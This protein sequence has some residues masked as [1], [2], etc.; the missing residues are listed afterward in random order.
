ML[1]HLPIPK[2]VY[3]SRSGFPVMFHGMAKQADDCTQSKVIYSLLSESFDSLRGDMFYGEL[4]QFQ[5]RFTPISQLVNDDKQFKRRVML[6]TLGS[7]FNTFGMLSAC[8]ANLDLLL[9][10]RERVRPGVRIT[11]MVR[12]EG[13]PRYYEDADCTEAWLE[14]LQVTSYNDGQYYVLSA[15]LVT[16][17]LDDPYVQQFFPLDEEGRFTIPNRY[18]TS[19][20]VET[21]EDHHHDGR[22][23]LKKLHNAFA[24]V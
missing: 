8:Q 24:L 23:L 10:F 11:N 18:V 5:E 3:I 20:Q 21:E 14:D 22:L 13:F 15:D 2:T 12:D 6:L 16:D 4:S 1:D 7:R 9:E 19:I 17:K